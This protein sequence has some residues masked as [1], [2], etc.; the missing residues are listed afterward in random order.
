MQR[1][2]RRPSEVRVTTNKSTMSRQMDRD[3]CCAAETLRYRSRAGRRNKQTGRLEDG[4]M[5]RGRMTAET[6]ESCVAARPSGSMPGIV[7]YELY[8]YQQKYSGERADK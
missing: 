6:A 8:G 3:E 2:R 1:E 5:P 4:R 7:Y